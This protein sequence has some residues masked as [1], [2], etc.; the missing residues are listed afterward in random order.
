MTDTPLEAAFPRPGHDHHACIA[1]AIERAERAFAA[2]GLRLTEQRRRVLEEIAA[3]HHAVGAYEILERLAQK[4]KRLAP[5]S[6]YRAID[7]LLDVGVV[8]RLESKNAFFACHT[9][10]TAGG[11]QIVLTC[12]R[13]GR[14]AEVPGKPVFDAIA[15]AARQV[16]FQPGHTIAEVSGVCAEC[17]AD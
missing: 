2:K 7:A 17:R 15:K 8:H 14:V 13:C 10:H 4:G 12:E 3:S 9:K 1:L 16:S 5:I 11:D 6:V